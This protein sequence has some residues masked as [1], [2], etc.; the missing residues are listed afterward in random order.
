MTHAAT[1][2][3]DNPQ[4]GEQMGYETYAQNR[5]HILQQIVRCVLRPATR[6]HGC[7]TQHEP[8]SF[9]VPHHPNRFC[10]LLQVGESAASY[11]YTAGP[12]CRV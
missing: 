12:G 11:L 8:A 9:A 2:P 7:L 5:V 6:V 3:P 1:S 4:T 10:H